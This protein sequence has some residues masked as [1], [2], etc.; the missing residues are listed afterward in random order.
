MECEKDGQREEMMGIYELSEPRF[1]RLC[2][3]VNVHIIKKARN[4]LK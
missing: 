2:A 4:I 1:T 3:S